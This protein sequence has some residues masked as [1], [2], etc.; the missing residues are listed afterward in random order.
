MWRTP[1]YGAGRG[2]G[3]AGRAWG[4]GQR[5]LGVPA[6]VPVALP[7]PWPAAACAPCSKLGPTT[8]IPAF[9]PLPPPVPPSF[10]SSHSYV[11]PTPVIDHFLLDYKRTGTF[12]GFPA[13]GVN[14]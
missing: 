8:T 10:L 7:W 11:I 5:S 2:G 12:T 14:W 13:L 4:A 9:T 1:S 6:A 3:G